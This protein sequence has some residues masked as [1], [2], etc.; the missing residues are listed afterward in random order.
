MA[1]LLESAAS[2]YAGRAAA[3]LA[4]TGVERFA[5]EAFE[6]WRLHLRQRL[7][8]LASAVALSSPELFEMEVRWARTAFTTH[9][10]PLQDLRSSLR[11][12]EGELSEELPA[13]ARSVV[14]EYLDRAYRVLD[15]PLAPPPELAATGGHERLALEYLAQILEGEN[16]SAIDLLVA[17]ADAGT[18]MEDLYEHVLV[19]AQR[20]VG[21]MW[22]VGEINV[23]EEHLATATT[24]QVLGL[25]AHRA[26]PAAR[27]GRTMLAASVRGNIHDMALRFATIS[28]ELQ[29]WRS[30]F[31][32]VELPIPDLVEAVVGFDVDLL[33]LSATLGTQ[34]PAVRTTVQAI[35]ESDRGPK[36]KV[37]VG[38][39]PFDSVEGLWKR[40]GAD[41]Y[42]PTITDA[43][44][45]ASRLVGHS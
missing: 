36:V 29:G 7:F 6:H 12:L 34:V 26:E 21:R 33:L 15:A 9:D 25:L 24:Q 39:R 16:R 5:P 18:S 20:E 14:Q 45:L 43:V 30:L 27:N 10:L 3:R 4:A 22:H 42:A 37:L 13:N 28:F 44:A 1:R 35:R 31:L 17:A 19:P 41:G 2:G 23:A 40:V 11:A 38:G 32:G 8:E